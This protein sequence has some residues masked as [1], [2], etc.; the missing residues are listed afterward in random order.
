MNTITGKILSVGEK[1]NVSKTKE[2]FKREVVIDC[3]RYDQFTGEPIEN[4]V[5]LSFSG[6]NVDA[7]L[8]F[9]KGDLVEVSFYLSGRKYNDKYITDI[10]GYKVEA[11]GKREESAPQAPSEPQ[12]PQ[13]PVQAPQ[14]QGGDLP[15]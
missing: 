1:V 10:V 5:Q 2:F 8:G 6:K 7:P 14:P 12:A 4:F 9:K 3:S 13:A 15:F 11:K